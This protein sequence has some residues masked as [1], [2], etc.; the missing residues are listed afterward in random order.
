MDLDP[1]TH[2]LKLYEG[3]KK[4][5]DEI[6]AWEKVWFSTYSIQLRQWTKFKTQGRRLQ[7]GDIVFLL[8]KINPESKNNTIGQ[9]TEVKS[10]RTYSVQYV[11]GKTVIDKNTFQV[12]KSG[13]KFTVDRPSQSLCYI[14][15]NE[16]ENNINVDAFTP[17]DYIDELEDQNVLPLNNETEPFIEDE[18]AEMPSTV[19]QANLKKSQIDS[20]DSLESKLVQ[21]LPDDELSS[22]PANHSKD[23]HNLHKEKLKV[24]VPKNIQKISNLKKK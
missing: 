24:A 5:D 17:I 10:D 8:D 15:S 6:L 7:V 9:I 12:T 11:R 18:F 19:T 22:V 2:N 16:K 1:D 23:S 3:V 13:K 4:L 21:I 20:Q 14:C